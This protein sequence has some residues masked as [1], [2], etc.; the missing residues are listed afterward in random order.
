MKRS[1]E[2]RQERAKLWEDGKAIRDAVAKEKR[3]LTAEENDK[4]DRIM[5]DV[6]KFKADIER[7]ERAER[8][9]LEMAAS[10]GPVVSRD[11]QVVKGTEK[12][13]PFLAS[14]E[15]RTAFRAF[16]R[17][18]LGAPEVRA[19][20]ADID[21]SGGFLVVPQQFIATLLQNV[22]DAVFIRQLATK[23]T[24]V[25]AASLGV[26]T[27][28]TDIS[29]SDWTSEIAT[30]SEDSSLAFG[31]RELTPHPLA[32]RIKVS[33]KLL[34]AGALDAEALVRARLA[35][36]FGI[37]LEKG[38]LTGSGAQQ[39][40]GLFTPDVNG[41]S[42]TRDVVTG[43]ATDVTADGLI[44]IQG[45]LKSAYWGAARWLFHRD[46]ITKIRK[47]K[48]V[49]DGTY[50]WQ[51]GLRGGQPDLILNSP[52]L[53][54]EY[55]PNVWTTG[56]YVG[57]YGDFSKYWIADALDLQVQRLDQLYAE[58]NQIGFIGRFETD[59][60]PV[61]EEAFVRIKTGT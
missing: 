19:L 9:E 24:L 15:Y 8:L 18:G 46:G 59:G 54:S 10:P 12:A 21:V 57:L 39:P 28:D 52:Y 30:G 41:I 35:Y 50:L 58:T 22:D 32:K 13:V 4:F 6:D 43:S 14:E 7:E 53:V 29:D 40:L 25:N 20:Q 55:V 42:T 5:V 37:T 44:N 49:A 16:L 47:L 51:P 27:L 33:Q 36:K 38:Y 31:K 17:N 60:M 1:I 3:A 34:R 26:P 45:F 56:L 11:S 61:L 48:N 23:N 2:L